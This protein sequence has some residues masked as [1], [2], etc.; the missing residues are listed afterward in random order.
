MASRS[1]VPASSFRVG[2]PGRKR[3]AIAA[4]FP[5]QKL[6]SNVAESTTSTAASSSA[7]VSNFPCASHSVPSHPRALDTA[8]DANPPRQMEEERVSSSIEPSL[9]GPSSS[10]GETSLLEDSCVSSAALEGPDRQCIADTPL[11]SISEASTGLENQGIQTDCLETINKTKIEST[12]SKLGHSLQE[13]A[14]SESHKSSVSLTAPPA[15]NFPSSAFRS[16]A[17]FTIL[18]RYLP[19]TVSRLQQSGGD[20]SVAEKS[21]K[22][23][24]EWLDEPDDRTDPSLECE[25][26]RSCV[27]SKPPDSTKRS[28]C[29]SSSVRPIDV[30]ISKRS[31][32]TV[33]QATASSLKT[34]STHSL[35]GYLPGKPSKKRRRELSTSESSSA[36]VDGTKTAGKVDKA[37]A[38]KRPSPNAFVSLRIRSPSI[39][40]GL[41]EVQ[42][43]MVE[44][45]KDV[46]SVLTSL[47]KLHVTLSI[48][49]LESREEEERF[50]NSFL[51]V[52]KFGTT[53]YSGGGGGGG[54]KI[55]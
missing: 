36:T 39:R 30:E 40:R 27:F 3:P 22:S 52:P 38:T 8:T 42:N 18:R 37:K 1:S 47:D 48:I 10:S 46:K 25:T 50:M 33:S 15:N 12:T 7:P 55:F 32:S 11:S 45:D 54:G 17:F 43:S 49:R 26:D 35:E 24:K 21:Q 34:K 5:A 4:C 28:G 23:L 13:S 9:V 51:F 41:E 2:R 29:S 53:H 31:L 6:S 44:K 14:D 16:P 20:D 19:L